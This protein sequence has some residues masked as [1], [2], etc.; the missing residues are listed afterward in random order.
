M[1]GA[2]SE[3]EK[4]IKSLIVSHNSAYEVFLK[5]PENT[6]LFEMCKA[7]EKINLAK[8]DEDTNSDWS[9]NSEEDKESERMETYQSMDDELPVVRPPYLPPKEEGVPEYTLVLDLDETLIH[10][11]EHLG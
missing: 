4:Q 3:V 9:W 1:A 6:K 8:K 10:Y 5:S 11:S 7:F 2:E